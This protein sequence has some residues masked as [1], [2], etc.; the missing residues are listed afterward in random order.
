MV[1][2]YLP[3]KAKTWYS[4]FFTPFRGTKHTLSLLQY[5]ETQTH[6]WMYILAGGR[7]NRSKQIKVS[8]PQNYHRIMDTHIA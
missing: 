2:H 1:G 5:A 7:S 3:N 4:T 8:I 6:A